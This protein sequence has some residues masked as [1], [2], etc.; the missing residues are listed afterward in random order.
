MAVDQTC[1]HTRNCV[2]L[3]NDDTEED[4]VVITA[5]DVVPFCCHAD[6]LLMNR[7]QLVEVANS[8]NVKLPLAMRIDTSASR[9]DS[10]IRNSIELLV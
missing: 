9:S 7:A 2:A 6:L 1:A 10:F 3:Q 5:L 4:A 8:L